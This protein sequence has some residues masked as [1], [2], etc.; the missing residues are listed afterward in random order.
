MSRKQGYK[1]QL[2]ILIASLIL[3]LITGCSDPYS[4][5]LPVDGKLTPGEADNITKKLEPTDQQ[6][7]RRWADRHLKTGDYGGEGTA[8]TVKEALVNQLVLESRQQSQLEVEKAK[9]AVEEKIAQQKEEELL[10]K[11]KELEQLAKTR[12][13]VDAE[14]RKHFTAQATGYTWTPLFNRNGEEFA[15]Q[16]EFK[17]KLTNKSPKTITGAAGWANISDVFNADLGSYPIRIEPNIKSGKTIEFTAV[18]EYDRKDPN[19]V[20]MTRTKSLRVEW[21]FESVAFIDGTNIDYKSIAD[22]RTNSTPANNGGKKK[23][24]L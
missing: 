3:I 13:M 8:S 1:K 19:H 18:M 22:P 6:I 21:F 7:F 23:V 15:R 20:E 9:K 16:W 5:K 10:Q 14:I 2:H 12:Q 17:L 11:R 4:T 24:E